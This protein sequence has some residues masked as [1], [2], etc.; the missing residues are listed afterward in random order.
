ME[1]NRGIG[2]FSKWLVVL[3]LPVVAVLISSQ[4]GVLASDQGYPKSAVTVINPL[5]PGGGT[6][7][8]LR[9]LAP[10]VQKYLG[11]PLVVKGMPGG[12]TTI[13]ASAVAQAKPDGYTLL[14]MPLPDGVLA[15]EFHGNDS[16]L[17]KFRGIYGWFEGPMDIDVKADS[18]F[19]TLA[20]LVAEGKKR[21]L[22]TAIMGIGTI[23]HLHILLFE[24]FTGIKTTSV[25]YGGGGPATAAVIKGEVEFSS[26]LST[27]SVRFVRDNQL[28][29][30]AV[31]GR[32]RLPALPDV[33]TIYE[34]GYKDYPDLPFVRGVLAPPGTPQ[35]VVDILEAAFKKA[36][37]DPG[38][39]EIMKK[40]GRPVKPFSSKAMNE[41]I[42]NGI[43]FAQE[44]VPFM[45]EAAQKK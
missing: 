9:N 25:P 38:F 34:S 32:E 18:P 11:Q 33:P 1:K 27:T 8:E 19:K 41:A 10:F 21:P 16:H 20:D 22:K 15:Q 6:D 29:V 30:L 12:A 40:Q 31:F 23:G 7:I 36:V 43:K 13:G 28:R 4:Q 44:Y 35:N 42:Q 3:L 39:R 2:R 26:G 45:K 5:R 24:K 14:C 17:E 37:D